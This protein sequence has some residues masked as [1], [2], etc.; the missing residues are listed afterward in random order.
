MK[1]KYIFKDIDH[2]MKFLMCAVGFLEGSS[3]T[4]K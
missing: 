4:A 3:T 1:F 2:T